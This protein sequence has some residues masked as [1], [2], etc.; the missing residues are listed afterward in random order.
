MPKNR[1]STWAW[2]REVPTRPGTLRGSYV[3]F[4]TGPVP[5]DPRDESPWD[6]LW[7]G[8]ELQDRGDG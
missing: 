2:T 4:D 8:S 7:H 3:R 1:D 6:T 5:P